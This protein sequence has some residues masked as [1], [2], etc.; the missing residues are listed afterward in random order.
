MRPEPVRSWPRA[1]GLTAAT[2]WLPCLVPFVAGPLG[3]C[4]HCIA[5]YA[6]CLPMVPGVLAPVL[7]DAQSAWFFV[8]GGVVTLAMGAVVAVVLREMPWPWSLG[9]QVV[10]AVLIGCEALG[11]A[12]LLRM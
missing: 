8:F 3:E 4:R 12:S 1:A 6:A 5:T 2:L 10:V 9:V 11:F 7:I